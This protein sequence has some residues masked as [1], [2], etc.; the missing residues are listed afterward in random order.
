MLYAPFNSFGLSSLTLVWS[1]RNA[2]SRWSGRSFRAGRHGRELAEPCGATSWRIGWV[3]ARSPS[4]T[5]Q[6]RPRLAARWRSNRSVPILADQPEFI[7]QFEA[8]AHLVARL[9]HPHIVPLY[10]YWREPG[11][12]YLVMRHLGGG[13]LAGRILD[14][15]RSA[16]EVARIV[17]QISAG[18]DAA[19][20]SGVIHRDVKPANILLDETGNAYLSDFGI[21]VEEAERLDPEAWLSHGSPAYAPPE[22]LN[23]EAVGPT[24]DV[25]ALGVTVYES[26]TGE[27]PFPGETTMAGLLERQMYDPIPLVR[28]LVPEVPAA[29]DTVIQRATAKSPTDRYPSAGAFAIDLAAAVGLEGDAELVR[30]VDRNPYKG[31]AAIDEGD[32]TDFAGRDRLVAELLE[33]IERNPAV[34]L[35]GPS[36]SGKSSVVRAGALPAIRHGRVAGADRWLITTMV[37]GADPFADL[38]AALLRVAV[39]PPAD[40]ASELRASSKGLARMIRRLVPAQR[41]VL[42]VVD[43]LEELFTMS[44]DQAVAD[45]FLE[46]LIEALTEEQ[47]R[48]HVIA[49]LRADFYDQPLRHPDFARLIRSATVPVHPLAADE[50]ERAITEP[51]RSVGATFEPGLVARITADVADQPGALP[52]LQYALTELYDQR[53]DHVMTSDAYDRLGGVTGALTSR[54]EEIYLRLEQVEQI[55]ARRV[56]GRL[57]SLGEGTEDTRRRVR[58]AELSSSGPT[59][60]TGRVLD[61]FGGAR[62][63]SFNRDGATREPT[64]EVAHEALIREWPRLRS[65]IDEDRDSLRMLRHLTETAAGWDRGR[66]AEGDLYRGGRLEAAEEWAALHGGNLNS[67]ESEF[68]S[69]SSVRRDADAER[70]R[71][72]NRRLQR[73]L[74]G[75]AVVA[76]IALVAGI[77]AFQQRSDARAAAVDAELAALVA[78]GSARV[79]DDPRLGLLLAAEAYRIDPGPASLAA[80]QRVLTRTGDYLGTLGAGRSFRLVRWLVDPDAADP[81]AAK[82]VAAAGPDGVGLYG[83]DGTELAW[84]A[85]P[86]LDWLVAPGDGSVQTT[87]MA[88]GAGPHLVFVPASDPTTL[89]LLSV[90]EPRPHPLIETETEIDAVALSSDGSDAFVL[91]ASGQLTAL[92]LESRSERWSSMAHP[93]ISVDEFDYGEVVNVFSGESQGP[94]P[95]AAAALDRRPQRLAVSADGSRIVSAEHVSI[96]TWDTATGDLVGDQLSVVRT[97]EGARTLTPVDELAISRDGQ[98]VAWA[99][100]NTLAVAAVGAEL[101]ERGDAPATSGT[102]VGRPKIDGLWFVDTHTSVCCS[103]TVEPH[104]SIPTARR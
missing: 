59:G 31:L 95:A 40:V 49:T 10:D 20:R 63:L 68:L 51:A 37:P 25:Y 84:L 56:F 90:D 14:G 35:V 81:D 30:P 53:V 91:E 50:L 92:D 100:R 8:E 101:A 57:V 45:R 97:D 24:A 18:L 48:L 67:L 29:V 102:S 17:G 22:Q 46:S 16:E 61:A 64:V 98:R 43:Q 19:H 85:E 65:W 86:V 74:A 80:L 27:I 3:R 88:D 71:R 73:L 6:R 93:E 2:W 23:R 87:V 34:M 55:E 89:M 44:T 99:F 54:A 38:E 103:L 33:A 41:E 11:G 75:V 42:L 13:S 72:T 77:V 1:R 12:A 36:G 94:V 83:L 69:A 58:R 28:S 104:C 47:A 96:R 9:E 39:D 82:V 76:A 15:R 70:D 5:G 26:L 52:L 4:S 66:R 32:A 60:T 79:T 7:R 78:E 21:A 62:L